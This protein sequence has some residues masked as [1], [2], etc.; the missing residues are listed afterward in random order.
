MA[1]I[2]ISSTTSTDLAKLEK[3]IEKEVLDELAKIIRTS[4]PVIRNR[5]IG[6]VSHALRTAPEWDSLV[7][8]ELRAHMG[9]ADAKPVLESILRVVIDNIIIEQRNKL[10]LTVELLRNGYSEILAV[11]GTNYVSKGHNIPWLDWLLFRGDNVILSGVSINL[12]RRTRK[13]SRT[14][15]AIMVKRKYVPGSWQV[16]SE[17]SGTE[18]NN[19]I[20]RSLQG[21]E[22]LIS[23]IITEEIIRRAS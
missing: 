21:V 23:D 13:S 3:D 17:F 15:S 6:V 1:V 18:N 19:F 9:I 20:S 2:N 22:T 11:P 12:E 7:A 16:P 14:G 4:I 5:V 10:D 8:G